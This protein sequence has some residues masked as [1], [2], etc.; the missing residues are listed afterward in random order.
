METPF[1]LIIVLAASLAAVPLM[2]WTK[3]GT[4]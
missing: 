3:V 4:T 2:I 1:H